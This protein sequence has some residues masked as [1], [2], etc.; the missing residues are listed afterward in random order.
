[1]PSA[2]Q[3]QQ[4]EEQEQQVMKELTPSNNFSIN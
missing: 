4:Q 2:Q 1:M 3:Q